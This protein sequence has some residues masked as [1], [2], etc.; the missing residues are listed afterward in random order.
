[1]Y[2][3]KKISDLNL[4]ELADIKQK[5]LKDNSI[6]SLS[7]S[8]M[9]KKFLSL[10]LSIN[11]NKSEFK[12]IREEY[13]KSNIDAKVPYSKKKF[14]KYICEY[15]LFF[16]KSP[17]KT[18][19]KLYENVQNDL[20]SIS[21][22][23]LYLD[24]QK[25]ELYK[26]KKKNGFLNMQERYYLNLLEFYKQK[27]LEAKSEI[28][29]FFTNDIDSFALNKSSKSYKAYYL[30]PIFNQQMPYAYSR[31]YW[32]FNKNTYDVRNLSIMTNKFNNF[33]I[34]SYKK[35][36]KLYEDNS[37]EFYDFA[38]KYINS[39]VKGIDKNLIE[40][41]E[42]IICKNH[43]INVRKNILNKIIHHYIN[44]DYISVVNMLPLQIEGIFHDICLSMNINESK[45][46]LSSLNEK[47]KMVDSSM[48]SFF[49]FEYYSFKFPILRNLVAHG[50]L[51]QNNYEHTAI[52]LMLDLLPVC[53]LSNCDDI[54]INLKIKL[55]NESEKLD[56]DSLL[57][58]IDFLDIEI[59]D[60][61][62]IEEK[63]EKVLKLYQKK[64]FWDY[65]KEKLSNNSFYNN[66]NET[67]EVKFI[68]KLK[69]TSLAK[70]QCEDFFRNLHTIIKQKEKK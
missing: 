42:E 5:I 46:E 21:T 58:L 10:F 12:K 13:I 35:I 54:H 19:L 33:P 47:L 22:Q 14:Y 1:M 32:I 40:Q 57:N 63:Y 15:Y 37:E 41:I 31:R 7:F 17:K 64:E 23:L 69:Q 11:V 27:N 52:M 25:E 62:L 29:D 36:C 20:K 16:E 2:K 65:L 60:F 3:N 45:L 51:L 18:I 70:V 44:K 30:M 26:T 49:Y 48:D 38:K 55:I 24:S 9:A 61:Y 56:Y 50:K 59:P 68:K 53:E 4:G 43:I 28:L 39:N 8:F 6:S 66:L 67:K 34:S